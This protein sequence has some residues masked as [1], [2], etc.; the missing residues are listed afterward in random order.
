MTN[1]TKKQSKTA[2][3]KTKTQPTGDY[4]VGRGRP[5]KEWQYKPG[6]SG[7]PSGRP[8]GSRNSLNGKK[9]L[10]RVLSKTVTVTEG[11]KTR[12]TTLWEAILLAQA[13]KAADG[14]VASMKVLL[15]LAN[16]LD[17]FAEPG[18]DVL[19]PLPADDEAVLE[20]ALQRRARAAAATDD[21]DDDDD[22]P[23]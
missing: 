9:A 19:T 15:D 14:H 23:Q 4:P 3:A 5:P 13:A 7:N 21:D 12:K 1:T 20:R 17:A 18:A 8:K 2:A 10:E 6:E 11:D 16:R 22:T